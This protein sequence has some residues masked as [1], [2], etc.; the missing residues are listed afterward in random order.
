MDPLEYVFG[1]IDKKWWRSMHMRGWHHVRWA[2]RQLLAGAE[3]DAPAA[4]AG[5]PL[6]E[7]AVDSVVLSSGLERVQ[8]DSDPRTEILRHLPGALSSTTKAE[9]Q[10]VPR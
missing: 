1:R 3:L 2:H 6:E 9:S 7:M 4:G 10:H 8:S 5:I